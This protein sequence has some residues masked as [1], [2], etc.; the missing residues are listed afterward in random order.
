MQQKQLADLLGVT[1]RSVQSY[2][3]GEVVPW[4][5]MEDLARILHRPTEWLLAGD[6]GERPNFEVVALLRENVELSRQ[7]LTLLQERS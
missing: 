5:F 6:N 4:R 3:S 7:I 1:A 2:E